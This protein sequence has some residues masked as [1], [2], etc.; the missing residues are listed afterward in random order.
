MPVFRADWGFKA[1]LITVVLRKS[2]HALPRAFHIIH[3][4]MWSVKKLCTEMLTKLWLILHGF[5][6]SAT[7]RMQKHCFYALE[8]FQVEGWFESV[9]DLN[10]VQVLSHSLTNRVG[11]RI[12]RTDP[13][14]SRG[15]L[16]WLCLL[17]ASCT[18]PAYSVVG[19]SQKHKRPWF[20]AGT[21][22]Q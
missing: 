18:S 11:E 9:W 5:I 14:V 7:E 4:G 17:P 22:Q 2:S 6:V 1:E 12:R 16:S 13:V 10:P 15:L 20:C 8:C 3:N 19:W 21:A